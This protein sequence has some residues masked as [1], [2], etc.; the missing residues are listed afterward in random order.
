MDDVEEIKQA[1]NK[2]P[3]ADIVDILGFCE[4]LVAALETDEAP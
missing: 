2:L 3:K 1:I 4:D